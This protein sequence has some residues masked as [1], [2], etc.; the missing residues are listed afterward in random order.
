VR[1][2]NRYSFLNSLSDD[3]ADVGPYKFSLRTEE[4][5][6]LINVSLFPMLNYYPSSNGLLQVSLHGTDK[7]LGVTKRMR[8][9]YFHG[10]LCSYDQA[11]YFISL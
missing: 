5:F 11:I 6:K 4:V 2:S 10:Q 8:R 9:R 1:T 3:P 7:N